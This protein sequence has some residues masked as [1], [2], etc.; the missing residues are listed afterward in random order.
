MPIQTF[1]GVEP[2]I[3]REGGNY[4]R[5]GAQHHPDNPEAFAE[6]LVSQRAHGSDYEHK[7]SAL[8]EDN[9]QV[10]LIVREDDFFT[11]TVFDA[12]GAQVYPA[13]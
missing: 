2:Q 13:P 3:N 9:G 5:F 1:P 12:S 10:K 6:L 8:V 11:V 4:A 7:L